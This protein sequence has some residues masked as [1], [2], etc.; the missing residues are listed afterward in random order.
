MAADEDNDIIASNP[1]VGVQMEYEQQLDNTIPAR[2]WPH[3]FPANKGAW[4]RFRGA[5]PQLGSV[6]KLIKPPE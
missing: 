3:I 1:D 6:L 2:I 4:N 5:Q